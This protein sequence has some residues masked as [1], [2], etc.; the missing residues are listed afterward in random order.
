M[1]PILSR[2]GTWAGG[3]PCQP[4]SRRGNQRGWA[5]IRALPLICLFVL[6]SFLR[7]SM[8]FVDYVTDL[9]QASIFRNILQCILQEIRCGMDSTA[10][11]SAEFV[12][13]R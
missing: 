9:L 8:V 12:P 10:W 2:F 13:Q 7:P 4:F 3:P 6:M 1:L 5:D 11:D